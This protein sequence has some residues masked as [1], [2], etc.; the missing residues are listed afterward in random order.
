MTNALVDSRRRTRVLPPEFDRRYPVIVKGDGVWVED[1]VGQ[2]L[3]RRD[4]RRLD[5]TRLSDTDAQT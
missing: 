1:S 4:E 2:A 3:P 5:G